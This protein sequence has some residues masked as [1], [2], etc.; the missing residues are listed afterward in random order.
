[1]G[2]AKWHIGFLQACLEVFL[3]VL[4]RV[5]TDG[6]V[7]GRFAHPRFSP[8]SRKITLCLLDPLMGEWLHRGL[9]PFLGF[10][11]GKSHSMLSVA[12]PALGF[13]RVSLLETQA[14]R[15]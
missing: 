6:I 1:M 13:V 15:C 11:A 5:E 4:L 3:G 14:V 9:C 7:I 2:S 8:G 10:P 12:A